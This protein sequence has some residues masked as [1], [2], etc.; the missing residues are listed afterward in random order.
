MMRLTILMLF[1]PSMEACTCGPTYTDCDVD[2]SMCG[3]TAGWCYG[4]TCDDYSDTS[5]DCG[6]AEG[7]SCTASYSAPATYGD[8][9]PSQDALSPPPPPYEPCTCGAEYPICD[10]D[11]S[12]CGTAGWCTTTGGDSSSSCRLC[13]ENIY[14]E[15]EGTPGPC[16]AS[17]T[18]PPPSP[19]TT[20]TCGALYPHCDADGSHCGTAGWCYG[21]DSLTCSEYS[22]LSMD[23]GEE[24]GRSCI[25]SY[26]APPPS[27]STP[28]RSSPLCKVLGNL[29]PSIKGNDG[30]DCDAGEGLLSIRITC[31]A[32]F[33][34]PV[35]GLE[36]FGLTMDL[37]PCKTVASAA[38]IL[39]YE[40]KPY[41]LGTIEAKV[42]SPPIPVPTLT[43][44]I[45]DIASASIDVVFQADLGDDDARLK[46]G[47]TPCI[48]GDNIEKCGG[49]IPGLDK[50]FP[51]WFLEDKYDFT[52][53]C[54]EAQQKSSSV[55][56]VAEED[57][58]RYW[59][60]IV[61]GSGGFLLACGL[62]LG[63]RWRNKA[64][65]RRAATLVKN[66][67]AKE[68]AKEGV[69]EGANAATEEEDKVASV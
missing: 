35:L 22:D 4:A 66:D 50:I 33:T 42:D 1:F 13:E 29:A 27:S 34:V 10:A 67:A 52:N 16:V 55:V 15:L 69:K 38:F 3:S 53:A 6:E 31:K 32:S 21:G 41:N 12:Q 44:D 54:I 37:A 17:Y 28:V 65:K 47:L 45:P 14:G 18:A 43:L 23:C 58:S 51:I 68:G 24:E 36:K 49:D 5:M 2:G 62:A 26:S 57:L 8:D 39:D 20:C 60:P 7:G 56:A 11:G 59:V 9:T 19:A 25:A 64:A 48:E 30:C 61:C 46:V 63:H 40:D